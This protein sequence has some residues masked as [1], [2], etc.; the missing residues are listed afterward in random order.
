MRRH[1]TQSKSQPEEGRYPCH[2]NK[3]S[4]GK[5]NMQGREEKKEWT[6]PCTRFSESHYEICKRECSRQGNQIKREKNANWEEK[7]MSR[8]E[9]EIEKEGKKAQNHSC[10]SLNV[11][12]SRQL[13]AFREIKNPN[14]GENT[15]KYWFWCSIP[16][17][18]TIGALW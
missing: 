11:T 1:A 7:G 5:E 10:I 15:H 13:R 2:L 14:P 6:Y 4:M 16:P 3:P 12:L 17:A 9:N 8:N 18:G